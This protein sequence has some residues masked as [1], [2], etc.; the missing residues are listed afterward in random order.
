MKSENQSPVVSRQWAV[1]SKLGRGDRQLL[2]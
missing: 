1:F 2:E